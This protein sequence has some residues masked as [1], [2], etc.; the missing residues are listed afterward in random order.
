MSS[1]ERGGFVGVGDVR[2]AQLILFFPFSRAADPTLLFFSTI[3][4]SKRLKFL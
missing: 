4:R 3:D 1:G 2:S